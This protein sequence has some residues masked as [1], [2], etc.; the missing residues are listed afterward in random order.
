MSGNTVAVLLVAGLALMVWAAR[1]GVF[2]RPPFVLAPTA[3]EATF[4]LD[5]R[6]RVLHGA[7]VR[8]NGVELNTVVAGV[9]VDVPVGEV[10][11][12]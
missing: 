1:R 7:S 3:R 5:T 8:V 2:E 10:P 6:G 4:V 9:T 12:A 11:C